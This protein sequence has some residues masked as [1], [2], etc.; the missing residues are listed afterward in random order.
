MPTLAPIGEDTRIYECAMLYPCGLSQKEEAA[1]MKEIDA[2]FQEVGAKLVAKDVWGR[3]GLAYPIK[4]VKEAN[5]TIY[6][7]EMD[8]LKLQEVDRNLKINKSVLRHL[9]VKPP[10]H[11]QIVK[12]SDAYEQWI[13]ERESIDQK[14]ARERQTQLEERVAIKARRK[15]QI[16][17]EKQSEKPTEKMSGEDITKHIDKLIT[18]D[19][20]SI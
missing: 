15:A 5:I 20:D 13:K 4:G 6:Y 1:L 9:F 16:K 8:P 3:R 14:R 18:D 17:P 10:K 19:F 12:F 7:W 11:Y 2:Y